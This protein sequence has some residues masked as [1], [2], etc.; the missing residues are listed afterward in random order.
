MGRTFIW[1]Y[2]TRGSDLFGNVGDTFFHYKTDGSFNFPADWEKLK[3]V[4]TWPDAI[5]LGPTSVDNAE[6]V[7]PSYIKF[8]AELDPVNKDINLTLVDVED[9]SDDDDE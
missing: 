2:L 4:V 1:S 8:G 7:L 3:L 5:L 6:D 9:D